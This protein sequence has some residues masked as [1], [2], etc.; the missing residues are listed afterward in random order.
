MKE[1]ILAGGNGS[2]LY[3]LTQISSKQQQA[4]FL[5][6]ALEITADNRDDLIS[7]FAVTRKLGGLK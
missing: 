2:H 4:V 5:R 3:T 7:M 6:G 1:I